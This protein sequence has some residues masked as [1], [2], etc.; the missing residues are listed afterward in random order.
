MGTSPIDK[1][2]LCLHGLGSLRADT[3]RYSPSTEAIIPSQQMNHGNE[4]FLVGRFSPPSN[5]KEQDRIWLF[6]LIRGEKN[7]PV[8]LID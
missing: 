1:I 4:D 2:V 3:P 7:E 8:G 6:S 5:Q